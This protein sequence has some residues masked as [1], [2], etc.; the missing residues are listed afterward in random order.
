MKIFKIYLVLL[1]VVTCT[2][3]FN[4]FRKNLAGFFFNLYLLEVER[5]ALFDGSMYLSNGFMLKKIMWQNNADFVQTDINTLI[6][7]Q[8]LSIVITSFWYKILLIYTNCST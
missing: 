2:N 5:M 4:I 6:A 1:F 8:I 3:Y 7:C